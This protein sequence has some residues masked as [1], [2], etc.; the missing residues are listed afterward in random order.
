MKH[1]AKILAFEKRLQLG[2]EIPDM[3]DEVFEDADNL[4]PMN[5]LW[6]QIQKVGAITPR[7]GAMLEAAFES[8][9]GKTPEERRE[10][11]HQLFEQI[12]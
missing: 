4:R 6:E 1:R 12:G 5:W 8:L 2:D 9:V 11:F 3:P 10:M 7:T